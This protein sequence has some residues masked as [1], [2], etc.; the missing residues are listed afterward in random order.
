MEPLDYLK[1]VRRH[2]KVAV[3]LMAISVVA[4][5]L[6]SPRKP[7]STYQATHTLQRDEVSG[8]DGGSVA[9][10]VN[11]VARWGTVGEVPIRAAEQLGYTGPLD[12]LIGQ[13]T[14]EPDPDLAMID[15]TAEASTA[16]EAVRVANVFAEQLL[17][18]IQQRNDERAQAQR[19][20]AAQQAAQL[21]NEITGLSSQIAAA[22]G[23]EAPAASVL[24]AER[25][26]KEADLTLV[27]TG[28]ESR[29]PTQ[30]TSLQEATS[31]G[32]KEGS[33]VGATRGQ[34]MLLAGVVAVVLAFGV[35]IMLDRSDSRLHTRQQAERQFGLPVLAEVPLL[36]MR[37]RHRAAVHGYQTNAGVAEAYRGLRTALLLFRDRLPLELEAAELASSHSRK[38]AGSGTRQVIVVTSPDA[39]DGKSTTAANLAMAYAEAGQSVL[40]LCWDFWRPVPM[41]IFDAEDEPGIAEFLESGDTS[42]APFVQRTSIP[43]L[44]VVP[45]GRLGQHPTGRFDEG[46]AMIEEARRMADVVIIDTAPILAA[47]VTRELVTM[48]DVVIVTC[49]VGRTTSPAAER[50]AELLERL[51]A[52]TLG[53]V[54]VGT[55]VSPFR[56]DYYAQSRR[57]VGRAEVDGPARPSPSETGREAGPPADSSASRPGASRGRPGR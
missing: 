21:R 47:S 22:G 16:D 25:A 13:V 10:N 33:V 34:R 52:P 45:A 54:I 57:A 4:V 6:M 12:D 11:A 7:S 1:I 3:A 50:C 46:M 29:S 55:P 37:A 43:G 15:I 18:Y 30:W 51:G 40:L 56:S 38:A 28:E 19:A 48:A 27:L 24:V 39:G 2:W 36:S 31:A 44:H 8:T 53:L 17:G 49:R 23:D 35:A 9:D 14:V 32:E 5:F 42:L 26:A 41:R 20:E